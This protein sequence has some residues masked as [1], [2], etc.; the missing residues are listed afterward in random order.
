VKKEEPSLRANQTAGEM[1]NFRIPDENEAA[2][3]ADASRG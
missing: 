3:A 2:G 1:A